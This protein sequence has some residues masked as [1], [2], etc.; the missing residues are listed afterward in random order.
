MSV[1]SVP[2][3]TPFAKGTSMRPVLVYD[4]SMAAYDLGPN[5]PLKP[6]RFTLTLDLIRAYG[7]IAD[8]G[9]A[10]GAGGTEGDAAGGGTAEATFELL[11]PDPAPV[12]DIELVHDDTYI[13][14][15]KRASASPE[16]YR[17]V[18]VQGIGPG[19]TPP[20]PG[21]HEAAA[22]I[23]GGTIAA[24]ARVLDA[25]SGPP[26]RAFAPAGGLH[27]AHRDRAS[28]FCVYNDPA[29]AIA[30]A[31][32]DRPGVRIAYLDIDAHHGDGVEA[33]F[34]DT[35]DV[36]TISLHESGRYLFPGT[37][38]AEETGAGA[39][40]GYAI[41][42]PM[43]P[44]ADAA[45]Y[46]LAFDEV[47]APALSAFAPDV[48][49][50]Q[51]GADAHHAD[52]LTHL[53]LTLP[54]MRDLYHRVVSIANDCCDGRITACGGGGYGTYSVVPRAW[55]MLAAALLGRE[56][57]EELP[58]AWR[59]R[60]SSMSDEPA[61]RTLTEEAVSAG[62]VFGVAGGIRGGVGDPGTALEYTRSV[63]SKLKSSVPLLA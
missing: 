3:P 37:G 38:R 52:P 50:A 61:P 2:R 11:A 23:C 42:V 54:E 31:L 59:H 55:T 28:G 13:E 56:L 1:R 51:C 47:V 48:L 15:V 4:D 5:H 25:P 53:G 43:P 6:E 22:L 19:D 9:A 32:R 63:A 57:P 29:V 33:A 62:G 7:L 34:Y 21:L 41:N 39:G 8:E 16:S 18:T 44:F 40:L 60:S 35:P 20:A 58:E 46:E 10:D 24:L 30:V 14:T 17:A 45:C 49:V 26:A 36:L 27:H 12:D